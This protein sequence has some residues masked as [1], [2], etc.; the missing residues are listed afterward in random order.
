M[1]TT[2]IILA[3]GLGTR[4]RSRV[5]DRP[6]PMASVVV[7]NETSKPFLA[8][9]MDYWREQG[10]SRFILSVGYLSEQIVEYFGD[11]YQGCKIEYSIEPEPVGTGG[12]LTLAMQ[13]LANDEPFLLLN[14]D[15]IFQ[16]TLSALEDFADSS[17]AQVVL[18]LFESDDY[19]RYAGMKLDDANRVLAFGTKDENAVSG[20]LHKVNGGVYWFRNKAGLLPLFEVPVLSSPVS[21][22]S[23][24][25][26]VWIANGVSVYGKVLAQPFIDMGLPEDY[27]RLSEF[28]QN[29]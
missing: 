11:N 27:D 25:F 29:L 20:I 28:L 24:I 7:Q 6:K 4:L 13:K 9:L 12:A 18:S 5:N 16:V 14:G 19:Q 23:D 26:P 15:T 21:L 10:V 22:E 2:A 17:Q 1:T 3:G 8:I